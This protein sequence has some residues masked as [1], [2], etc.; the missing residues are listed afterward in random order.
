MT[1]GELD[2][3][4]GRLLDGAILPEDQIKLESLMLADPALKAYVEKLELEML[5]ERYAKDLLPLGEK[6]AFEKQLSQD[7][8]LRGQLS[9]FMAAYELLKL[10]R[11]IQ[12]TRMFKNFRKADPES[13]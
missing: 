9:D 4:I 2:I 5:F 6:L 12:L 7:E 8:K 3:I 11:R 13:E 1:G 10:D